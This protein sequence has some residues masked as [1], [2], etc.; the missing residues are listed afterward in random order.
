[1]RAF[2]SPT[3]RPPAVPLRVPEGFS[4]RT[5]FHV[6]QPVVLRLASPTQRLRPPNRRPFG[7][8][9]PGSCW[10]AEGLQAKKAA[11]VESGDCQER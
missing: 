1:M 8:L 11:R 5:V 3:K 2:G 4:A 10:M 9:L 7:H 6:F